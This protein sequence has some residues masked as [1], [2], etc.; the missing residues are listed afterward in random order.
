MA[1]VAFIAAGLFTA[2][3]E[4]KE[5]IEKLEGPAVRQRFEAAALEYAQDPEYTKMRE[6]QVLSDVLKQMLQ[7]KVMGVETDL[8]SLPGIDRPIADKLR[9]GGFSTR[10]EIAGATDA[11]LDAV[12]GIGTRII[13]KLRESVPYDPEYRPAARLAE[14]PPEP[15]PETDSV[16]EAEWEPGRDAP[17][18][19][20]DREEV[21]DG[22]GLQEEGEPEPVGFRVPD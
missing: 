7:S 18:V 4:I 14:K 11:Q 6:M 5:T 9:D 21:Q 16:A 8:E 20:Q 10:E 17:N 2:M 19:S 13:S 22:D 1:T 3:K 15:E 12:Y